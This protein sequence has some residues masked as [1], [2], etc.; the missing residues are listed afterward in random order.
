[1]PNF[2]A[3]KAA[4]EQASDSNSLYAAFQLLHTSL[5]N[6]ANCK[7]TKEDVVKVCTIKYNAV[8]KSDGGVWSIEISQL[9][10]KVL[11]L[12]SKPV[13]PKP[14]YKGQ[15]LPPPYLFTAPASPV[16]PVVAPPA[17]TMQI[18]NAVALPQQDQINV[19]CVTAVVNA[20]PIN[21]N[22]NNNN[23]NNGAQDE[24]A[25]AVNVSSGGGTVTV[26]ATLVDPNQMSAPCPFVYAA[27][28]P[29]A[30]ASNGMPIVNATVVQQQ[31]PVVAKCTVIADPTPSMEV[32]VEYLDGDETT[33]DVWVSPRMDAPVNTINAT[34]LNLWNNDVAKIE[35]LGKFPN[36]MR[37]T[38]RSNEI[39]SLRG[40]NE[41]RSLRWADLSVNDISDLHGAENMPCLEWLDLHSNEFK[42]VAGLSACPRLTFLNMYN[43][44]LV[45]LQG[46]N[47]LYAL[48][49]FNVSHNALKTIAGLEYCFY[50][51]EVNLNNNDLTNEAEINKLAHLPYLAQIDISNNNFPNNGANIVQ[52]FQSV[53]PRCNV[54]T[55]S[56]VPTGAGDGTDNGGSVQSGQV[57]VQQQQQNRSGGGG[58][59]N[60][61]NGGC[62][63]LQ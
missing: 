8:G 45:N 56:R 59:T 36:L 24:K 7:C 2:Q 46:I 41:A 58:N 22:N 10:Y 54:I 52:Y 38:L 55:N 35:N 61:N 50:L 48:R 63:V 12:F 33:T 37:L 40:L 32:S 34:H 11:Q 3:C 62:C 49:W 6:D 57:R 18:V 47:S 9:Y 44:D 16:V 27:P 42:T 14:A 15:Q 19:K 30:Y 23:N 5:M 29:N 25:A 21:T 43:S 4:I 1:M 31:Q 26:N 53:N 13:Q 17:P 51:V 39:R 28:M 60:N 20:V